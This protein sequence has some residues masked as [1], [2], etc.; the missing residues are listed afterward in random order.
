MAQTNEAQPSFYRVER[1]GYESEIIVSGS[2]IRDSKGKIEQGLLL[3]VS[4][5]S[6]ADGNFVL[7]Q[8]TSDITTP[9]YSEALTSV[10]YP[11]GGVTKYYIDNTSN[12]TLGIAITKVVTPDGASGLIFTTQSF[13]IDPS[14][15]QVFTGGHDIHGE[16]TLKFTNAVSPDAAYTI[17]FLAVLF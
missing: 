7:A 13:E 4:D 11:R 15:Q 1:Q 2:G 16:S 12:V 9:A 5:F 3:V 6:I 14:T 8:D 17:G 10:Y